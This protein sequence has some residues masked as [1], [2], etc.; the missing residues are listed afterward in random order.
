MSKWKCMIVDDEPVAVRV[1]RQHLEKLNDFEVVQ[2]SHNAME[3]FEY[4]GKHPVDLVLLDIEM[5]E[6]NGMELLQSL[7]GPPAVIFV[8]AHRD[9]AVEGFELNAVDYLVKPV[10][11]SRLLKALQRFEQQQSAP[12]PSRPIKE[13][14]IFVTVDRKKHRVDLDEITYIE[15][16]KD[17]VRIC[18]EGKKII[19]RETMTV[20]ERR[21]PPD[22]FLRIHRSFIINT[23]RIKTVSYDE[24][25]LGKETLPVGRTYRDAV[26]QR[27]NIS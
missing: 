26:M 22:R 25:S 20:M 6:L 24:I 19:T 17:Y 10:P 1:L 13:A 12:A 11:F 14:S 2:A 9:F 15:G 8:T 18:T 3:A 5:P 27:L 4:L 23:G 21:L 16:L 7:D